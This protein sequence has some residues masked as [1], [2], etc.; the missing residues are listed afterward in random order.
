MAGRV[1]KA[2]PSTTGDLTTWQ[3]SQCDKLSQ[4]HSECFD[5]RIALTRTIQDFPALHGAAALDE[6]ANAARIAWNE[7]FD[8]AS[9]RA[10]V[11]LQPGDPNVEGTM[12][13]CP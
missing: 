4:M 12:T 6:I 9:E 8:K 11:I 13:T 1:L 2:T 5:K 7:P 10:K 3:L